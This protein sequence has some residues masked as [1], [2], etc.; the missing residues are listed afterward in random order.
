[1]SVNFKWGWVVVWYLFVNYICKIDIELFVVVNFLIAL[2]VVYPVLYSW[3]SFDDVALYIRR[4]F[5]T[6]HR[7]DVLILVYFK[8]Y[9]SNF[10]MVVNILSLSGWASFFDSKGMFTA[11]YDHGVADKLHFYLLMKRYNGR[12]LRMFNKYALFCEAGFVNNVCCL[13]ASLPLSENT[14]KRSE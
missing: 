4:G 7:I 2:G 8:L 13:L 14:V 6:F 3:M 10:L 1:M 11:I 12:L 5:L 9:F